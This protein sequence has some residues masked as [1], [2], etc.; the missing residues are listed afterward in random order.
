MTDASAPDSS[1]PRSVALPHLH[2]GLGGE[3]THLASGAEGVARYGRPAEEYRALTEGCAVLERSWLRLAALTGPD[4]HRF[5]SNLVT[6]ALPADA[7]TGAYGFVTSQKGKVLADVVILAEA[8]RHL[9]ELPPPA[10]AAVR[11]HAL[12]YRI[13]EQVELEPV[14][15]RVVLLLAGPGAAAALR[16]LADGEP[17]EEPWEH[18][19]M[20]VAGAPVRAVR[21]GVA[22]VPELALVVEVGLAEAVFSAVVEAGAVPAGFDAYEAV[23]V[24]RGV[25]RFGAEF[26]PDHLP[27]ETGLEEQAV[28]YEKGCYL[29]QEVV[30]RIHYRGGVNRGLTGLDLGEAAPPAAGTPVRFEGRA[31]GALG[32]AV[33]SPALGRTLALAVLHR[34]AAE[35]GA[36]VEVGEEGGEPVVG[37]VRELPFV[38]STGG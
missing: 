32:T 11:D 3:L 29:G 18:R 17:P 20:E 19:A 13:V 21:R 26:G 9:L 27:Q 4:R 10:Q 14:D 30:A 38:G 8:D 5:F 6:C 23:R 1:P 35:P 36:E 34:R 28:S 25:P 33:A 2:R 15:D 24:E 22:P 16:G 37:V 12:K 31:A 7:G